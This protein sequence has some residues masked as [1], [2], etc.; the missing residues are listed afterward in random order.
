MSDLAA[1]LL[2][3]AGAWLCGF[4]VGYAL[5]PTPREQ[6]N[7]DGWR[8]FCSA[9]NGETVNAEP[10]KGCK[11]VGPWRPI[12]YTPATSL[13]VKDATIHLSAGETHYAR[14]YIRED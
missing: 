11:W 8:V 2:S 7:P 9:H 13:S 14:P 10:P 6:P 12:G 4:A 1:T 5:H 3:V